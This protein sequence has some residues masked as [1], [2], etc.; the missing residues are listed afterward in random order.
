VSSASANEIHYLG[1]MKV[2][3]K[4]HSLAS[5]QKNQL[6]G[7]AKTKNRKLSRN[8]IEMLKSFT[9]DQEL[10]SFHEKIIQTLTR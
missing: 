7:I 3:L 4:Q 6:T 9:P 8:S 1:F 5:E 2:F 10:G